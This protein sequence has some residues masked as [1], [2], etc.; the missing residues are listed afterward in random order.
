MPPA[1]R[2]VAYLLPLSH[3]LEGLRFALMRGESLAEL[4]RFI[5]I[6]VAFDALLLP[7]GRLAFRAGLDRVR[8]AGALGHY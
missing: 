5:V 1:L 8:R 6:L 3:A 7:A 4:W 2:F